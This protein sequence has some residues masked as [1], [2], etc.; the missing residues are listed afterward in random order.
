MIVACPSCGKKNRVPA[1]HLADVG[2]C[3]AC[4]AELPPAAEPIEV[5]AEQFREIVGKARVPVLVD[6]WAGWCAPCRMAA[7]E[8]ARAA[9]EMAGRAL[10]LKVDTEREPGIAAR[11]GVQGIPNFLVLRGGLILR[12]QA[13]VVPAEALE[14][15]LE[16]AG[17]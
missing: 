15:W 5:D 4:R 17:A 14:G 3:G 8:V 1:E 10:V 9:R 7:P 16:A 13:G 2:R 6:F 11:Y 12:Q